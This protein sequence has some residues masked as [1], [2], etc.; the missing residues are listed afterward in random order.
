MSKATKR[1]YVTQEVCNDYVLPDET[2][3]VA[4]VLGGRGNNLHEVIDGTG[5]TYLASMPTKFRKNV[6]IKR[7]DFVLVEA[8]EEGD[9]VKAEIVN[10]LYKEQVKYV[11]EMNLWPECFEEQLKAQDEGM[12]PDDMLPPSDSDSDNEDLIANNPN[13]QQVVVEESSDEEDE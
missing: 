5:K 7:G 13:R 8:I 10:I 9:K 6:W 1:K 11:K 12:I 2:K 3:K 4:K